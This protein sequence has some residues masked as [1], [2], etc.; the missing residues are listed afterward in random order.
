M[1]Y[2]VKQIQPNHADHISGYKE[3][4]LNEMF[5]QDTIVAQRKYDGERMLVHFNHGETYCTS[6]RFSKKTGRYMENQ[7]KLENL[8]TI[9]GLDYTVVDC[10]CYS[11]TWSDIAGILHSL[12][13]RAF[14]LQHQ[15]PVKFACF[16]CL[17][18][19]GKDL[20]ELPYLER[21]KYLYRVLEILDGETRFHLVEQ[22]IP[23]TLQEA[24]DYRDQLISLGYEGCVIKSLAKTY[25]DK[26]ASL[27]AKRFET[28]DVVVTGYQ[29]GTGKYV[30]TVGA[31]T[32]GYYD[33]STKSFVEISNVNCGTDAD[34]DWWRDNWSQAQYSILEVKCQEITK[35]SLRHPVY[36]RKRP[37]KDFTMVTKETIF[38]EEE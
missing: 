7:D 11:N 37:D 28:V 25:Y 14:A 1:D 10:E 30:N 2:P 12:P 35:K 26:G 22:I 31:L 20:R 32:V 18:Y 21:L 36:I 19:D 9:T 34:R 23:H 15:V 8:P 3:S 33:P 16:D 27:K 24:Y 5:A 4:W 29:Q 6:R 13:E 38:K 17:F